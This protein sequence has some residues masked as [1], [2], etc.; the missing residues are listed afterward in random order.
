MPVDGG[1]LGRGAPVGQGQ[2]QL[3]ECDI[4]P[5]LTAAPSCAPSPPARIQ[6][7]QGIRVV[8]LALQCRLPLPLKLNLER[9]QLGLDSAAAGWLKKQGRR[10]GR[11]CSC[12]K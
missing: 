2:G 7:R 8:G 1:D 5:S 3:A 12:S 10:V 11:G 6:L 9:S 4:T